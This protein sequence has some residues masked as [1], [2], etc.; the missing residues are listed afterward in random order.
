MVPQIQTVERVEEVVSTQEVVRHVDVPV[1][2]IQ[3]VVRHVPRVE[4]IE[5]VVQ[6]P[7]PVIQ[8]VERVVEVPQ[9]QEVVRHVDV[10]VPQVQEVPAP[11][12]QAFE[13]NR[14]AGPSMPAT[15]YA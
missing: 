1:P 8:T 9:V 11:Y 10:P 3:E 15:T 4:T 14:Y 2:Q 6:V 12:S 7:R 13:T 5:K